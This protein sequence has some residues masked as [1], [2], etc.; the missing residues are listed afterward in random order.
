MTPES[1][2][3]QGQPVTQGQRDQVPHPGLQEVPD[4]GFDRG[5][6]GRETSVTAHWL[7]KFADAI[8][9]LRRGA[10]DESS[11][12]V[13]FAFGLA[14]LLIAG[15]LRLEAWR[16]GML[17]LCITV[18]IAA[19]YFNSAIEHVVRGVTSERRPEFA[20]ALHLA[21]GG[22]LATAIGASAVGLIT[23]LPPLIARLFG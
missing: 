11:L 13:H 7:R 12:R 9:G 14:T 3:N 19:E 1:P 10:K 23:L 15:W 16:W 8:D 21:A 20:A 17:G 2:S 22:V 5:A 6:A 18:V 4:P